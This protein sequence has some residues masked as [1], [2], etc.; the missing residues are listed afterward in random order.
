ME[1]A[2]SAILGIIGFVTADN[3]NPA[4]TDPILEVGKPVRIR[5]LQQF[6]E[7]ESLKDRLPSTSHLASAV[8][9]Y[10]QNG[11]KH[12]F[13]LPITV[14]HGITID[15]KL[16][17]DTSWKDSFS[18]VLDHSQDLEEITILS[19]P[20]LMLLATAKSQENVALAQQTLITHCSNMKNRIAILDA[21]DVDLSTSPTRQ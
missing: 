1:S 16:L 15:E 3:P 5:S 10:Y 11:G 12:A 6:M 8:I 7:S 20:D 14:K 21:P 17:T 13:V 2:P 4:T 18:K 19:F 9:G